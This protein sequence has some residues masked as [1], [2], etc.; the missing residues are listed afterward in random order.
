MSRARRGECPPRDEFAKNG[1]RDQFLS[2]EGLDL[3]NL[4]KRE[5]FAWWDLWLL[6]AQASNELDAHTYSHGV[7]VVE[8][9]HG[10]EIADRF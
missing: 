5:L 4:S 10:S 9:G 8:P 6:Q 7:F 2:E 3:A 1:P